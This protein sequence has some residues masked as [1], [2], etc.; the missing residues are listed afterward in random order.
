MV[1]RCVKVFRV[2]AEGQIF[3]LTQAMN[4]RGKFISHCES[5]FQRKS[6]PPFPPLMIGT[7]QSA[8]GTLS[9]YL[10]VMIDPLKSDGNMPY[11]LGKGPTLQ[12]G[13]D[14]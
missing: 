10:L 5:P 2:K 4:V 7:A 11:A 3:R 12:G 8:H 6:A 14:E 1:F 9:T 13:M